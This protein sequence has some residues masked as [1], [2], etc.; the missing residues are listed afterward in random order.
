[1]AA[2]VS[3]S[4]DDDEDEYEDV[5]CN[6]K[7]SSSIELECALFNLEVSRL[8]GLPAG[9]RVEEVAG[10][11]LGLVATSRLF[12]G[13]LVLTE[14]PLLTVPERVFFDPD[15][16]EK[17]MERAINQLGSGQREVEL[18]LS[19]APCHAPAPTQTQ[20]CSFS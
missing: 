2:T 8:P 5:H 7:S 13:D 4:H 12:P 15:I 20:N 11:G 16:T 1:M 18:L 9:C 3:N 19:F 6:T 10:R 17:W 14:A